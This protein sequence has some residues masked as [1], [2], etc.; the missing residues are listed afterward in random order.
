MAVKDKTFLDLRPMD[1]VDLHEVSRI[2][3][4]SFDDPWTHKELE[5]ALHSDKHIC[6]VL[7]RNGRLAGYLIAIRYRT[8]YELLNLAVDPEF[9]KQGLG[10]RLVGELKYRLRRR[11]D[12]I[13]A[14]VRETNLPAQLFFKR[15]HFLAN[16]IVPN[17]FDLKDGG[18]ET[19]YVF[20]FER[21]VR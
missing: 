5:L 3:R 8:H 18:A 10:G 13:V 16:Y 12:A 9:R 19:A 21:K 6:S 11:D 1:K 20:E 17:Y 2:E 4:A 14:Y 15:Q 7:Q